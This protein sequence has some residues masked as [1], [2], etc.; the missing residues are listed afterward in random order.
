MDSPASE[1][2]ELVEALNQGVTA[3]AARLP[4]SW[5]KTIP[6]IH[7]NSETYLTRAQLKEKAKRLG[8]KFPDQETKQIEDILLLMIAHAEK[9]GLRNQLIWKHGG[10]LYACF[11]SMDFDKKHPLANITDPKSMSFRTMLMR[12]MV[13]EELLPAIFFKYAQDNSAAFRVLPTA[14]T[15]KAQLASYNASGARTI[16]IPKGAWAAAVRKARMELSREHSMT[17]RFGWGYE[18]TNE[19]IEE[20]EDE[21]R[22]DLA[23]HFSHLTF[24]EKE[25]CLITIMAT[26][27]AVHREQLADVSDRLLEHEG[28]NHE[29]IDAG[30]DSIVLLQNDLSVALKKHAARLSDAIQSNHDTW[31]LQETPEHR[32]N[33]ED[34]LCEVVIDPVSLRD[35]GEAATSRFAANEFAP[36]FGRKRKRTNSRRSRQETAEGGDDDDSHEIFD[37][38]D[39]A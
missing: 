1:S 18:I 36:A 6:G 24:A 26:K 32:V 9:L 22:D 29:F 39:W 25:R 16:P 4:P 30:N 7:V 3:S 2:S 10:Y 12:L 23:E 17:E 21:C 31:Y 15:N 37:D 27:L 14:P 20:I 34:D 35:H 38:G 19:V 13:K 28:R 5:T 33:I 8:F 11:P